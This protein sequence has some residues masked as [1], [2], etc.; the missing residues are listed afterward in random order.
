MHSTPSTIN[1]R[2]LEK[3]LSF[4]GISAG[5]FFI[6]SMIQSVKCH[7]EFLKNVKFHIN[8]FCHLTWYV[9]ILQAHN[10]LEKGLHDLIREMRIELTLLIN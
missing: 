8:L 6:V 5:M 2:V 9:I 1:C 7:F 3:R 10:R 4:S